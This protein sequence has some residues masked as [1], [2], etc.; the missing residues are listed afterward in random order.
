MKARLL[1]KLLN[2]TGYRVNNN[3]SYIGVGSPLCHDLISVNKKTLKI[4][5]ALDTFHEGRRALGNPELEFIWDKLHELV[6]NGQ[7][8]DI[9]DGDDVIENPITVYTVTDGKL[10]ETYTDKFGYP[11]V[12]ASGETMYENTH[13]TDKLDAI[14]YGIREH[15]AGIE[16][17]DRRRK[18]LDEKLENAN[19][20]LQEEEEHVKYLEALY[21]YVE[22]RRKK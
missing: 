20:H 2:D 8:R 5:Y 17:W 9:I 11:N 14:A 13:Y 19:K 12:T 1:T 7:I 21:V 16:I 18:D 4:K 10:I 22:E 6:D 15:K 3:E